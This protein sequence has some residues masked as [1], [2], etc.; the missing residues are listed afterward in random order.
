MAIHFVLKK[1]KIYDELEK[2]TLNYD[3]TTKEC[4]IQEPPHD[5]GC[6]TYIICR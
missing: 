5:E 3:V 1:V 2:S 6:Q 4:K